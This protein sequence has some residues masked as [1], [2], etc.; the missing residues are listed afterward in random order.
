MIFL[1]WIKL[2]LLK[3]YKISLLLLPFLI[4]ILLHPIVSTITMKCDVIVQWC[5]TNNGSAVMHFLQWLLA[6]IMSLSKT[7]HPYEL[8]N[9]I[10]MDFCFHC[11]YRTDSNIK[12]L[13]FC[14]KIKLQ[15]LILLQNFSLLQN[16]SCFLNSAKGWYF[17]I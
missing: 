3:S 10:R 4:I 9:V 8:E 1:N 14:K 12:R 15:N 2:Q 13:N 5:G 17:V 16:L 11:R 6:S 7:K